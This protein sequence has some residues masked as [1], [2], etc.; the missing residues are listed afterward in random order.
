MHAGAS[1]PDTDLLPAEREDVWMCVCVAE[2]I[3]KN[4]EI[5]I[6]PSRTET[7]PSHI[8]CK[9]INRRT[10][11]QLQINGRQ[12]ERKKGEKTQR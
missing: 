5:Y 10:V 8:L 7:K 11:T 6:K 9:T 1:P 2:N 4:A 3:F 12:A